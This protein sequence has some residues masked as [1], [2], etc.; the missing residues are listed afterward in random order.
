[1][2]R[3]RVFHHRRWMKVDERLYHGETA[4]LRRRAIQILGAGVAAADPGRAVH[5]LVS[6][7][8]ALLQIDRATYDLSMVR[9]VLVVGTGKASARMAAALESILGS[10]IAAGAVT[11]KYGYVHALARIALVEAGHPLPDEAGVSGAAR[12]AELASGATEDDLLFV[13]ISGGGSA[14]LPMPAPGITL[15]EKIAA[16]DLLL[17]SGATITEVNTVRKHL[18]SIKGGQ[19]ARLAAPARVVTL[20]LSD[21]LGNPLDAIASGP[22]V[23]DPTTFA[24]ALTIIDRFSLR[25][26]MPASVLEHL[27]RGAAGIVPETP[28]PGDPIF[29]RTSTV[30]VGDIALA[31][32]AAVER[33][34][35]LGYQA[36][37]CDAGVQG[38]ARDVGSRFG[39]IVR[40]AR[41]STAP[42]AVGLCLVMGGETTVTVR[43]RGRG[44]RN[45][46]LALGAAEAIAGLPQTLVASFGT[47]GTDGPTDAAGAVSDGTTLARAQALGLDPA[48]ALR[49]NDCYPFFDR[50]GDLIIS[51]PTNTNVDDLWLGLVGP[52]PDTRVGPAAPSPGEAQGARP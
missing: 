15:K 40:D 25:G 39:T 28:K 44:G 46:E 3:G 37:L 16:T 22:T 29:A 33:A 34:E 19:L 23:P 41:Y 51:G 14:L 17:R 52:A 32:G 36:R 38:E 26:T 21:V 43:G 45:Q 48:A 13:V 24:D 27:E 8:G 7:N 50:L 9:R 11:T 31:A 6:R 10:R 49:D 47:D 2:D 4:T 20:T 35:A 42:A 1:M 30:I 12:I 18:S 5:R